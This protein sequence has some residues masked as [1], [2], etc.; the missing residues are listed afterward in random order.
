MNANPKVK[1]SFSAGGNPSR[2]RVENDY[3]A[4]DPKSTRALLDTFPLSGSMLEPACGEGHISKVLKEYYPDNEIISTDLVVR[5]FG[6]GK[7]DFLT[8]DYGRK[9][10]TIITNP[11]FALMKPFVEKA[12]AL[13]NKHVIMFGKIQFLEGKG[14][15]EFLENSPLKHVY[16]FSERQNPLRNGSPVD[17]NGKKWATTMCF[18]WFV[19]EIG[20]EG[21]PTVRWL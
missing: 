11:P 3:Y 1:G 17:E 8:H 7:V 4:T 14:R 16:V 18:A 15:K 10:D 19:W 21:E 12:L 13:S 2:G 5:G 6:N 9:F 20:Y